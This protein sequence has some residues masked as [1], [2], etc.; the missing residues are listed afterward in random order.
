MA[1]QARCL[2]NPG[3]SPR[4]EVPTGDPGA[5]RLYWVD[6]L[7]NRIYRYDPADVVRFNDATWRDRGLGNR[8]AAGRRRTPPRKVLVR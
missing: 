6:I 4:A 1:T 3:C 8:R 5:E 2:V 7:E